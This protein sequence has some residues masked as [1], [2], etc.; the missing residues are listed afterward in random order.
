M[1]EQFRYLEHLLRLY[2]Y[3]FPKASPRVKFVIAAGCGAAA[4]F[5]TLAALDH[6]DVAPFVS[7]GAGIIAMILVTLVFFLRYVRTQGDFLVMR[8][9]WS[10]FAYIS[11]AE[12]VSGWVFAVSTHARL[13]G[14]MA[15]GLAVLLLVRYALRKVFLHDLRGIRGAPRGAGVQFAPA[16]TANNAASA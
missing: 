5:A 9:P 15:V 8:H 13:Y 3:R 2:D 12:F 6:A 1:K 16:P 11:M 7:L 4:C 10:E 14:Q